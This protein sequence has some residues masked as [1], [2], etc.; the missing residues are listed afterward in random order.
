MGKEEV[1][2]KDPQSSGE[3]PALGGFGSGALSLTFASF[4]L[5]Y[6]L[7]EVLT[8]SLRSSLPPTHKHTDHTRPPPHFLSGSPASVYLHKW[9]LSPKR[10]SLKTRLCVSRPT[11]ISGEREQEVGEGKRDFPLPHSAFTPTCAEP[12]ALLGS[13]LQGKV[14]VLD[15]IPQSET[16]GWREARLGNVG[17]GW[18][19]KVDPKRGAKGRQ[20]T[21]TCVPFGAGALSPAPAW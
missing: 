15:D 3:A 10:K 4:S 14:V 13:M 19:R 18:E 16:L 1:L 12:N 17:D 21:W 11:I 2:I 20:P 6:K 5:V 7:Q 8:L 9:I